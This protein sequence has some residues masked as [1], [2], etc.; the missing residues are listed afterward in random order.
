MAE[1]KDTSANNVIVNG[2]LIIRANYDGIQTLFDIIYPIGTIYW[3]GTESDP[4]K[5]FGGTWEK[6]KG[7]F[8]LASGGNLPEE[9]STGEITLSVDKLPQHKHEIEP[10]GTIDT[11]KHDISHS[12]EVS[13]TTDKATTNITSTDN[14]KWKSG[15]DWVDSTSTG[16]GSLHYH[17]YNS[18]K[19]R[20]DRWWYK[21]STYQGSEKDRGSQTGKE[22]S[23]HTHTI[24]NHSHGLP[25]KEHGE[26]HNRSNMISNESRDSNTTG[27]CT[28]EFVGSDNNYTELVGSSSEINIMPPYITVYMWERIA[29]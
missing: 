15:Y 22:G 8:L 25:Y 26:K 27:S 18:P 2:N 14:A 28:M 21:W 1:L 11:H 12:H 5:L 20:S 7:K 13:G 17:G 23:G 29:E 24:P 10:A 19:W 4:S 3:T 16:G 9:N 6:I